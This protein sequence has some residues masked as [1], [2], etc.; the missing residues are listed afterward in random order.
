MVVNCKA[1]NLK[2]HLFSHRI[3]IN[4]HEM[5]RRVEELGKLPKTA[6][7][8]PADFVQSFG[9]VI[10]NSK[11]VLFISMSSQ[12]SSTYQNALIAARKFPPGRV[13]VIDSLNVTAGTAMSNLLAAQA[14]AEGRS[15]LFISDKFH[16][17][18]DEIQ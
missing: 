8:S 4:T 17:L 10:E 15:A 13:T 5:Y 11:D 14:A 3:E 6:A 2:V 7:P 9:L 16:L 1:L 12:V 18:R